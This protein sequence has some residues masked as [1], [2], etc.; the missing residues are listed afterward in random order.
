MKI[1]KKN[2]QKIVIF[3]SSEKSPYVTWACF[4]NVQVAIKH[5]HCTKVLTSNEPTTSLIPAIGV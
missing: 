1:V 2:Q 5:S 3:K 4:R